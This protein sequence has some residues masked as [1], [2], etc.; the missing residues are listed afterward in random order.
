MFA[1]AVACG[2]ETHLTPSIVCMIHGFLPFLHMHKCLGGGEKERERETERVREIER[3]LKKR[4][5]A[6]LPP[7]TLVA[8]RRRDVNS[9]V[10]VRDKGKWRRA[11]NERC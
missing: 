4:K 7:L 9:G 8:G 1:S 6:E 2:A 3:E 5:K 11:A 10:G